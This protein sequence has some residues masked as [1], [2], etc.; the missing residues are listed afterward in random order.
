MWGRNWRNSSGGRIHDYMHL[1]YY[2]IQ[3]QFFFFFYFY[4]SPFNLILPVFSGLGFSS[5]TIL[6]LREFFTFCG[7]LLGDF[8]SNASLSLIARP[9]FSKSKS[10][11]DPVL[12][13]AYMKI[14]A[15]Y[16]LAIFYP[17]SKVTSLSFSRSDLL[18][19]I[20]RMTEFLELFSRSLTQTS[21]SSKLFLFSME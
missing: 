2:H 12:A 1:L 10:T 20:L 15:L 9:V 8:F 3:Q 5:I 18:P 4:F 16:F 14:W 17:S 21:K 7:F 13:L 11:L 6:W 19:M